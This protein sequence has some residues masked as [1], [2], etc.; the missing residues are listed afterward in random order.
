MS[1]MKTLDEIINEYAKPEEV[2]MEKKPA[3]VGV[4][5]FF[6]TEPD[7]FSKDMYEAAKTELEKKSNLYTPPDEWD[8]DDDGHYF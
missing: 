6:V 8:N 5:D 4:W 2:V 3:P 7:E 1:K